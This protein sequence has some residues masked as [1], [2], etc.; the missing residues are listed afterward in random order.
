M[1]GILVLE[2]TSIGVAPGGE[3]V[4]SVRIRNVGHVVDQFTLTVLGEA[5]AWATVIPP[6]LSLFPGAEGTAEIH[7]RPPRAASVRAGE[8]DFALR[9]VGSEDPDGSVVE[10]GVLDL[11]PFT[12]FSAR[13]TPRTSEGKRSA[14]HE[15]IVDNKGNSPV[16]VEFEASDPDELLAFALKPPRL[17][18]PA[19]ASAHAQV[20]VAARKGFM[21]GPMQNR[22]FMVDVKPD[23]PD[24]SGFPTRLDANFNQR[25]G[26]P[27]F[28]MPLVVAVVAVALIVALVPLL[29]RKDTVTL[30]S[31][32]GATATTVPDAGVD[33]AA[34]A[35]AEASVADPA[36]PTAGQQPLKFS[37]KGAAL[38]VTA[39]DTGQEASADGIAEA[40]ESPGSPVPTE[41]PTTAPAGPTTTAA[42][43]TTTVKPTTT[44]TAPAPVYS[45]AT[46]YYL[47]GTWTVDIDSSSG[48]DIWWSQDT[49]TARRL[50][51][52][53]SQ[54][55]HIFGVM[56]V[57]AYGAMTKSQLTAVTYPTTSIDGSDG[58][59]AL[60]VGLV[61]GV[62]TNVGRFAK[63]RID[64]RDVTAPDGTSNHHLLVRWVTYV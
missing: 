21:R 27:G 29:K 25:P 15:I 60:P 33:D 59:S 50:L 62:K 58:S 10:E 41:P 19:G 52:Q 35:A 18:I 53:G 9:A 20:K 38:P 12:E 30:S 22:Q 45:S 64:A 34:A 24:G 40:T 3:A 61:I 1:A 43:T 63:F 11:A 48:T 51:A 55:F 8:L 26:M 37:D 46:N 7:F 57:S 56:S 31:T 4:C 16:S 2:P 6:A 13:I 32:K 54:G 17:D 49:S 36:D 47:K 39:S 14:H 44:T 42:P 5:A 28:I 23:S